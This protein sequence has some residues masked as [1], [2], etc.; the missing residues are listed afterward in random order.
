MRWMATYYAYVGSLLNV[1][2]I[3]GVSHVV[4]FFG[5]VGY[6]AIQGD[7]SFW[8]ALAILL[9]VATMP[10]IDGLL[11]DWVLERYGWMD[12]RFE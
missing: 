12:W 11:H 10:I 7:L 3:S 8:V 5:L 6:A 1:D 2:L 4:I 9:N